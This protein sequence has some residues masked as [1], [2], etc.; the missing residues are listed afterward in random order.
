MIPLTVGFD[1]IFSML[2]EMVEKS[3][4]K[5][6]FPFYDI[7]KLTENVYRIDVALA[8]YLRSALNVEIK[9]RMLIITGKGSDNKNDSMFLYKGISEKDFTLSFRL[10]DNTVVK[11]AEFIDGILKI[12]L[13]NIVPNEKTVCK[14]P[15]F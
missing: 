5:P 8:G 12:T 4:Q 9:N 11:T 6:N 15:I 2:D 7:I 1:K 13:E 3:N 14:I 10:N